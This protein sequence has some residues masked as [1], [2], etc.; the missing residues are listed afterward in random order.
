MNKIDL[1]GIRNQIE[2]KQVVRPDKTSGSLLLTLKKTVDTGVP[3]PISEKVRQISHVSD[4]IIKNHDG[5]LIKKEPSQPLPLPQIST[6]N[7]AQALNEVSDRFDSYVPPSRVNSQPQMIPNST[8]YPQQNPYEYQQYNPT[9]MQNMNE[10]QNIQQGNVLKIIQENLANTILE[11]FSKA[12]I[13]ENLREVIYE[14]KD[15]IKEVVFEILRELK[16]KTT[17]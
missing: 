17:K 3:S 7:M 1:D 13:K 6:Q 4:N 10:S 12:S 5:S 8:Y 11:S 2:S 15:V 9:Y 16:K 14:N